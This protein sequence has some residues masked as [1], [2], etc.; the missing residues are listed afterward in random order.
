MYI[1]CCSALTEASSRHSKYSSEIV[2]ITS[3][4]QKNIVAFANGFVHGGHVERLRL[5]SLYRYYLI[6][7][8]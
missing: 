3:N 4:L 2:S 6:G 7:H 8:T 1:A 5:G